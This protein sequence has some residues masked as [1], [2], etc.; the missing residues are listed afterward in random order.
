M[1]KSQIGSDR[2]S[3]LSGDVFRFIYGPHFRIA[4]P[5]VD[6][7]ADKCEK[8]AWKQSSGIIA[9]MMESGGREESDTS[10]LWQLL[11]FYG[12]LYWDEH[13]TGKSP[14]R[15]SILHKVS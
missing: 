5:R 2:A 1:N 8:A 13:S 12:S 3:K 15:Q 4:L 9:R 7:G 6:E 14:K 11:G 10:G